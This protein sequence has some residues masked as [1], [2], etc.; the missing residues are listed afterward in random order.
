M[1]FEITSHP[2]P[3]FDERG[4]GNNIDMIVV[5]YTGM[6]S[7]LVALQR[8]CDPAAKVSAHYLIEED[9][10]IFQLVTDDKRAW[11]AGQSYWAGCSDINS[12]SIGIELVNPGHE[13]GYRAFPNEQIES[14]I[15]LARELAMRYR[16]PR[17]RILCHSDVAP[18][19]K[20]DPGELFPW[21]R[22]YGGGIGFWRAAE[23]KSE[24][25]GP[26]LREG[27]KGVN[28]ATLK[29]EF[30]RFGYGLKDSDLFD[31]ELKAVV[32]AFQRHWRQKKCDGVADPETRSILQ[33]LL[34]RL[35]S[36]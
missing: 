3:N 1:N 8:L 23:F 7:G 24:V 15:N 31:A 17:Y 11:H 34:M 22:L 2:S 27:A 4:S 28:I 32:V 10:R 9:G 5:H 20:E 29:S 33:H 26:R 12:C 35:P 13:F 30:Q 14:F 16:I 21:Q 18:L 36:A 25:K 6:E 19:R